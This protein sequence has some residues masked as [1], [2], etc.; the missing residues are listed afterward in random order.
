MYGVNRVR[1]CC[2]I[3]CLSI[4]LDWTAVIWTCTKSRP[5]NELLGKI[6][7]LFSQPGGSPILLQPGGDDKN[8]DLSRVLKT[9]KFVFKQLGQLITERE[10]YW[11][12]R[13]LARPVLVH[14][15]GS[16]S[17]NV[18]ATSKDVADYRA[19][20]SLNPLAVERKR[21]WWRDCSSHVIK[22]GRNHSRR[23]TLSLLSSKSA[24][25]QPFKEKMY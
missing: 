15:P 11:S 1:S 3:A 6:Y 10:I 24:F 12:R 17:R 19:E 8:A 20:G 9:R 14:V 16:I 25:S 7:F 18:A 21:V 2:M 13:T 22:P 4:Q 5:V 23:L